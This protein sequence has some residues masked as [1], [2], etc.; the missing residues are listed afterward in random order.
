MRCLSC[1]FDNPDGLKCC[2]ECDTPLTALCPACGFANPPRVKFCGDCGA[3]IGPPSRL[4]S[5]P[6]LAA[7]PQ[8]PSRYT[9]AY[10]AEKILT[11]KT[12]LEGERQQVTVLFADLKGSME[13]LA[14]RYPE[15]ARHLLD[16]VL[17]RM[18]DA[19][20]RYKG[21]V[22]PFMGDGAEGRG[23]HWGGSVHAREPGGDFGVCQDHED[24]DR[25]VGAPGHDPA[26]PR[27]VEHARVEAHPGIP[28]LR[29]GAGSHVSVPNQI[30]QARG[31][32]RGR[33]CKGPGALAC[34]GNGRT[35]RATPLRSARCAWSRSADGV[36]FARHR[37]VWGVDVSSR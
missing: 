24:G 36:P 7:Q 15:E 22:D 30:R 4:A 19:V 27:V 32:R 14:D 3:A 20:H 10:L 37:A 33:R 17:E 16:P 23:D 28:R 35:G 5:P 29:L 1:G 2:G 21:T 13:L 9:P 18:M 11:S 12:A 8:P 34:H 25:L 26:R 6:T 31:E